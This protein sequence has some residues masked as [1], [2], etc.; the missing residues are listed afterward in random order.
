LS[1][2]YLERGPGPLKKWH[3]A[4]A[5]GG[6]LLADMPKLRGSVLQCRQKLLPPSLKLSIHRRNV[7]GVNRLVRVVPKML[8]VPVPPVKKFVGQGL[9]KAGDSH[10]FI[11]TYVRSCFDSIGGEHGRSAIS[12]AAYISSID[13]KSIKVSV[14][15]PLIAF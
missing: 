15:L 12:D 1:L 6:G 9:P 4:R 3:K 8:L 13:A 10:D 11:T 5:S 2:S 14:A 7:A